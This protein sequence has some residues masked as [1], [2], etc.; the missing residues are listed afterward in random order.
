MWRGVTVITKPTTEALTT[1]LAKS[2][3]RVDTSDDDT[4]IDSFVAGA[5]AAIDGPDGIGFAL[6]TQTWRKAYDAFPAVIELPGA[7]VKSV[8]SLKY[9]DADG[10]EQT[11]DP[12][13]YRVDLNVDP[14]RIT[15]VYGTSWPTTRDI[16]SAVWVDYVLGEDSASDVP[17]DLIDALALLVGHR[18]ENREAV[19][20]MDLKEVPFAFWSIVARYRRKVIG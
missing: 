12:S 8:T 7:P 13:A 6:M 3:L 17:A 1:A 5:T 11:L 2:R 9:I 20:E 14:V 16:T 18:Y 4:L 10:A 19:S 15:P